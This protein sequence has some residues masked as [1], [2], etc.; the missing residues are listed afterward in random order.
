MLR[1]A[2]ALDHS[3][4]N[5]VKALEVKDLGEVVAIDC[6]TEKDYSMEEDDLRKKKKLFRKVYGK[7][8]EIY[9]KTA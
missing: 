1:V 6:S 8:L 5:V 7:P 3:H 2:D 9:W 4:G